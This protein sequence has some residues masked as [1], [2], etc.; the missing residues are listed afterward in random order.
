MPA[1]VIT[2]DTVTTKTM[3]LDGAEICELLRR[4]GHSVPLHGVE[5][6]V[7]VPGG[8]DWSNAKLEIGADTLVSVSWT[9]KSKTHGA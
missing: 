4:A 1:L 3:S 5:V 8:G 2:H 7:R 6:T 9:E